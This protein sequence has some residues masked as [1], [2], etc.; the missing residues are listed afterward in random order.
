MRRPA[1][2]AAAAVTLAAC[3]SP[4]INLD[5]DVVEHESGGDPARVIRVVDGDTFH[6]LRGGRDVTIRL[7]G[8]DTPEVDWYGGNAE[9]Y[10]EHAAR[11]AGRLIGGERVRLEFDEERRDPYGRTL[12]YAYLDTRMVNVTLLRRG[13][14][15]VTIYPPNDRYADRFRAAEAEAR[16]EGRGLWSRC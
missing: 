2:F 10:G 1:T 8:I 15:T 13:Y 9:C 12:A 5:G 4:G 3:S 11:F 6:V 14:A 7:I 16:D